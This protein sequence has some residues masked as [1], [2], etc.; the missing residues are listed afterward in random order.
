M[1]FRKEGDAVFDK[2]TDSAGGKDVK[3]E[4]VPTLLTE[5]EPVRFFRCRL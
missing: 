1:V 2:Q 4:G 3:V 5:L